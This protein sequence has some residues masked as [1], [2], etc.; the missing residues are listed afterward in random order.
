[1]IKTVQV[2]QFT[3]FYYYR[4]QNGAEVDLVMLTP[5]GKMVCI[6]IK[7]SVAPTISKGFYQSVEDLQPDFK[8]VITPSGERFD[9]QDG[10]RICPLSIF[11]EQ[12][13]QRFD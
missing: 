8:Y 12:E 13:L 6:E 7:F 11:L 4:T 1:M 10:L 9:R 5:K 3:D 2:T